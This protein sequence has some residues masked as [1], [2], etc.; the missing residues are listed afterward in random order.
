LSH[1][2]DK[3]IANAKS[4]LVLISSFIL[5]PESIITKINLAKKRNVDVTIIHG[6]RSELSDLEKQRLGRIMEPKIIFHPR[7]H[8]KAYFNEGE[9]IVTSLN[10]TDSAHDNRNI[11]L[12]VRFTKVESPE[13]YTSLRDTYEFILHEA[14]NSNTKIQTGYCIRCHSTLTYDLQRPLC[15]QCF[16]VWSTYS[17]ADFK[18][19]Y[20]HV[21]GASAKTSINFPVCL[22]HTNELQEM[23]TTRFI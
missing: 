23:H 22:N 11:E 1:Y 10:L 14:G 2:L 15:T 6:L 13:M 12:G 4:E 18:E 16:V 7:L 19:K 17:Q 8:A 9:A 20:C 3:I 5:I 21:C